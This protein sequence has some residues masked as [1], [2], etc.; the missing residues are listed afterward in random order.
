MILPRITLVFISMVNINIET[1]FEMHTYSIMILIMVMHSFT[2][3]NIQFCYNK[4]YKILIGVYMIQ[5]EPKAIR[6]PLTWTLRLC[7]MQCIFLVTPTQSPKLIMS[8]IKQSSTMIKLCF[9]HNYWMILLYRF[10][11]IM[12]QHLPFSHLV[13]TT[14]IQYYKNAQKQRVLHPST[15]EELQLSHIFWIELP[16]KLENQTIQIKVLVCDSECPYDILIGRTS[17]AHLSAWQDYSTNKLYIQKISIPIVAR[18]NVRILPGCTGIVSA[19]LKTSKSTFIPRNTIMGKG[20][21]YVRPFD[22]MLPLRPIE[23]ELENS[24]CCLEINNSW[25]P[26]VK[27]IFGNFNARSKGLVQANN[28]KH[29]PINQYLHDGVTPST[30][31]PK[32]LAYNKPI[33]P[34][35]MPRIL[36]CTDT[37]TDDTNVPTKDDKYPW[38]DPDDK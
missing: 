16:L 27:F 13:L 22:K 37:I 21:A 3:T 5:S 4:S 11:S 38:L 28:S 12:E 36:T 32:P 14:N 2:K 17:L 10:L 31:S 9:R 7:L 1:L 34:S 20:I 8:H 33:D 30:L 23:I 18:N 15:W 29:F 25:D 24:K 19:A 6:Y 26:T 35:E